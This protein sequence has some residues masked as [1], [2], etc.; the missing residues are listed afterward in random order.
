MAPPINVKLENPTVPV[1]DWRR[2]AREWKTLNKEVNGN[3]DFYPL[4]VKFGY[5]LGVIYDVCQS[6]SCLL[7]SGQLARQTSYV[8]A[9]G[10]FGSGV[11]LL[12][13]CVAGELRPWKSTLRAALRWLA[14]PRFPQYERVDED[15]ELIST[16][17]GK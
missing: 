3:P 1:Q 17:Q 9:Y 8:P 6:V 15:K 2:Q 10:L 13:R 16:S 7:S 14:E 5:A 12:G 11:E 4:T